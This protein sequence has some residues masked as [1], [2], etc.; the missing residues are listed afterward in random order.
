M[1]GGR[2]DQVRRR[3]DVHG[4]H[5]AGVVAGR[6]HRVPEVGVDRRQPELGRVLGEGDGLAA[7]G[8]GPLDLL[9]RGGRVPQRDDHHRD[10]PTGV[11]AGQLFE[12]EVVPRLHAGEREVL[13]LGLVEHLTAVAGERREEERR[14]DEALVHVGDPGGGLVAALAHVV[15]GDRLGRELLAGLAGDGVEA[16]RDDLSVLV[17][18]ELRVAVADDVRGAIAHRLGHPLLPQAGG[19]D[20]VVIDGDEPAERHRSLLRGDPLVSER[21]HSSSPLPAVSR[22]V[23]GYGE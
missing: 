5:V 18:P 3:A 22:A 10:E 2:A 17:D 20:E 15:V 9:G 7:E 12:D 14:Q 13:V 21:S 23:G 11:V 4:Q 19:F 6:Q 1:S 8:G 16:G